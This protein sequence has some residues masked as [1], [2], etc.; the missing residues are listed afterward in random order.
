[1]G[2]YI[3]NKIIVEKK[4][5]EQIKNENA[6]LLFKQAVNEMEIEGVK[7]ENA[8]MLVMIAETI[9]GTTNV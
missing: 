2:V 7:N 9:G 4:E 3:N 6:E 8:N 1:M 5:K